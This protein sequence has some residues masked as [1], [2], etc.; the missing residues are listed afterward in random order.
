MM[1]EL[2]ETCGTGK[3]ECYIHDYVAELIGVR[4]TKR[5][6]MSSSIP[7]PSIKRNTQIR[8]RIRSVP[9]RRTKTIPIYH[10]SSEHTQLP[11]KMP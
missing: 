2:T 8:H 3:C 7:E 4:S 1:T 5:S 6:K 9:T 11:V 10:T